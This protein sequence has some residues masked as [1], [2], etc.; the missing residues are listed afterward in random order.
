MQYASLG[1]SYCIWNMTAYYSHYRSYVTSPKNFAKQKVHS[2]SFTVM[3][4]VINKSKINSISDVT[5]IIQR[6]QNEAESSIQLR[7]VNRKNCL[8]WGA[9]ITW[10]LT[11]DPMPVDAVVDWTSVSSNPD[12]SVLYQAVRVTNY[13]LL[14]HVVNILISNDRQRWVSSRTI[15]SC[16]I[17]THQHWTIAVETILLTVQLVT[18]WHFKGVDKGGR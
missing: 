12:R 3:R 16:F 9:V 11:V 6:L 10:R 15:L 7:R 4:N 8:H 2:T 14:K 18:L 5:K 13:E 1:P 17:P